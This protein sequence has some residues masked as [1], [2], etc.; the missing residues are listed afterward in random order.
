MMNGPAVQDLWMILPDHAEKSA[1]ELSLLLEGY[2]QFMPFDP[3][4][5]RLI[6]PL[7]FMRM[8]YFLA[9]TARQRDDGWFRANNPEWGTKSFWIRE[10]RD[11][12]EQAQLIGES[13]QY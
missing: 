8:I 12:A 13:L 9:W 10:T 4:G 5:L 2:S 7:R 1:R 6:E 11:L 3:S